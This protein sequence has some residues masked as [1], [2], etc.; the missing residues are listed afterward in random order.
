MTVPPQT[1]DL[2]RR[3]LAHERILQFLLAEMAREDAPL[4]DRLL[5]AFSPQG[6]KAH[7]HDYTDAEDY[8]EAFV[9]QVA[10][11]GEERAALKPKVDYPPSHSMTASPERPTEIPVVVEP[12][13]GVWQVR[14]STK[15]IGD[16]LDR[17][18]AVETALQIAIAEC[19]L[20][21]NVKLVVEGVTISVSN[22]EHPPGLEDLPS[23]AR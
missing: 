23:V 1:T 18:A 8:A 7:Q 2:E 21:A 22:T 5:A 9:R 15:H 17:S 11:L 19:R 10:K 14:R 16:Y 3:V 6:R 12:R 4:L 13:S 20:G